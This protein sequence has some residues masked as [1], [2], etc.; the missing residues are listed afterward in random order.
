MSD[1]I[2]KVNLLLFR[3]F[4]S[5]VKITESPPVLKSLSIRSK[6]FIEQRGNEIKY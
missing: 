2:F 5:W 3:A 4:Q 6:D 1:I